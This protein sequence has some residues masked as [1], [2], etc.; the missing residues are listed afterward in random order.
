M[1][2]QADVERKDILTIDHAK[3]YLCEY[4]NAIL[5]QVEVANVPFVTLK[6]LMHESGTVLK[7]NATTNNLKTPIER[8]HHVATVCEC[9]AEMTE[10]NGPSCTASF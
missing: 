7:L 1:A 9:V 3:L 2:R 8:W 10:G 5:G 4:I 6:M